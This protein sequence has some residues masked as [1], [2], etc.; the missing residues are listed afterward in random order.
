MAI[1][2]VSID[3]LAPIAWKLIVAETKD[4]K[5]AS[6]GNIIALYWKSDNI[7]TAKRILRDAQIYF[8]NREIAELALNLTAK[9]IIDEVTTSHGLILR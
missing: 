7:E 5:K 4:D 3:K 1:P 6:Y 8:Q 9:Y 2:Y